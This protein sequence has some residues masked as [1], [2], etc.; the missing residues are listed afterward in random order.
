MTEPTWADAT[1]DGCQECGHAGHRGDARELA[2]SIRA[3][4]GDFVSA[5]AAALI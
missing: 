2:N 4:V 3:G 1:Y 5:A